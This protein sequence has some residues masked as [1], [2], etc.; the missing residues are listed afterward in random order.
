MWQSD[1]ITMSLSKVLSTIVS[2][3]SNNLRSENFRQLRDRGVYFNDR[4]G[5]NRGFRNPKLLEKLRGYT[6]IEDE[7][8][9]HLPLSTFD[10]HG[11]QE[12]QYYDKLGTIPEFE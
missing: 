3:L 5:G 1:T 10:P 6:G 12:D 11:F 8:G 7:Y 4:L 2:S 9:S